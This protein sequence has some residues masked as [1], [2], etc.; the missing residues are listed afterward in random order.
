VREKTGRGVYGK[1]DADHLIIRDIM[2]GN[3]NLGFGTAP[4]NRE[5]ARGGVAFAGAIGV[6]LADRLPPGKRHQQP[7]KPHRDTGTFGKPLPLFG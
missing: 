1:D 4:R 6:A 5:C 7:V 3:E 2:F